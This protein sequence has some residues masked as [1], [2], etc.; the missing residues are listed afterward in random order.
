[1]N[2]L[3]RL[4]SVCGL[5][6]TC[7]ATAGRAQTAVPTPAAD[8]G[9]GQAAVLNRLPSGRM[10]RVAD[11]AFHPDLAAIDPGAIPADR[12]EM[13]VTTAAGDALTPERIGELDLHLLDREIT[14]KFESL[15]HC[16]IDVARRRR[17]LPSWITMDTLTLRWTILGKGQVA[18]MNVV[19]GTPV[20][21]EVLACITGDARRWRFTP[22]SGGDLRLQRALVFRLL[23]PA[24]PRP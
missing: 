17:V 10:G 6:I 11:A 23:P 5:G 7:F 22:P 2:A 4:G 24:V 20:D 13:S 14:A 9:S 16:R 1:M 15:G 12:K 3:A 19:S 18:A 8:V 21:L